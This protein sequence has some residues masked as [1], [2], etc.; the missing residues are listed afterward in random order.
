MWTQEKKPGD[1]I[2][3]LFVRLAKGIHQNT[4]RFQC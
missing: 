1:S 2:G 4:S 3:C